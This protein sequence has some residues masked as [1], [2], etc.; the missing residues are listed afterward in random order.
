VYACLPS[1]APLMARC[2]SCITKPGIAS[3][4]ET[5]AAG[6]QLFLLL[7]LPQSEAHNAA[8]AIARY[9]ARRFS[10]EAFFAWQ[11]GETQHKE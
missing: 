4:L 3:I 10:P 6:R 5:V 1:L 2:G 8:Y 11:R 9:R 7:G